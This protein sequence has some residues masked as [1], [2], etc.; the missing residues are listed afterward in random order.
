M[1]FDNTSK[2]ISHAFSIPETVVTK[3]DLF[4][5]YFFFRYHGLLREK[6]QNL[7]Q[8][9]KIVVSYIIFAMRPQIIKKYI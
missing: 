1:T 5:F 9:Y 7:N 2:E 8:E 6:K 4:Y 3:I